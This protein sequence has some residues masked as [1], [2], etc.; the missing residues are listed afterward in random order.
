MTTQTSAW[1]HAPI[2]AFERSGRDD[3]LVVERPPVPGVAE[4]MAAARVHDWR[5]VVSA[6]DADARVAE[7]LAELNLDCPPLAADLAE[8]A[9]DF[10]AYFGLAEAPLRVELVDKMSCPK[11]HRDNV[12]VRLVTAYHGAG[13]EYVDAAA[14]D[15]IRRSD[16]FALVFLKGKLHPTHAGSVLHRSPPVPAGAKRL[17]VVLDS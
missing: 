5:S 14:P 6:A 4:A 3:I 2:A 12:R 7:A 8:L 10:L 13:T 17:C 1:P 9:R 15:D 16:T 11:F